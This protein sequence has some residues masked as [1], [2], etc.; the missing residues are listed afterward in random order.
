MI[1]RSRLGNRILLSLGA[2]AAASLTSPKSHADLQKYI[3]NPEPALEWR[4]KNKVE[5]EPGGERIFDLEFV[6]QSWRG[7]KWRHQLQVYQPAGATP[8][9]R[10]LRRSNCG[11]VKREAR[12]G[13]SVARVRPQ[14]APG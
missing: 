4:M 14:A 13:G 5:R 9:G 1:V 6:S 12:P 8:G 10:L 7:E 11:T 2:F 3:D